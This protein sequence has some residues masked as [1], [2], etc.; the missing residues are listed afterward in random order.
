MKTYNYFDFFS[1]RHV[2]APWGRP[3][4]RLE[5]GAYTNADNK[6]NPSCQVGEPQGFLYIVNRD[7]VVDEEMG[8]INVFCRFGNSTSGTP[9]SHT[10]R[11]VD[12][13]IHQVHT[14]SV[15]LNPDSPSPQAT[16]EGRIA[17]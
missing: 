12:G 5:G 2:E 7:Y 3:C 15:N 4:A 10:I 17:R 8:V 14:L 16:A 6:P 1:D 11:M 9:D 13:R